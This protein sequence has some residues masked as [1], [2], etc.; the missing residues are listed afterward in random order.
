MLNLKQIKH[1]IRLI[2]NAA[3]LMD[4]RIHETGVSI[5]AHANEH[6]DWTATQSLYEA[7]P[8]SARREAFVKW[9]TD[10]SPLKFDKELKRFIKPK[11]SKRGYDVDGA[12]AQP[13]W[14]Y[15]K[16]VAPKLDL[17]KL[18]VL[19]TLIDQAVSRVEKAQERGIEITGDLAAFRDRVQRFT[20]LTE[21]A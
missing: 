8:K 10:H 2:K 18:L 14:D 1:N 20:R 11:K 17:N 21:T 16:E 9:I 15:T 19:E 7:L 4:E 6:G 12:N 13:F 5:L 3:D